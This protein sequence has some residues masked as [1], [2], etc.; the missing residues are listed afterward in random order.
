MFEKIGWQKDGPNKM[1]L[2]D[3]GP[4][5]FVVDIERATELNE[6]FR[7]T[8][9]TGKHLQLTLMNIEPGEE[10][11]LEIHPFT[12]QFLRIEEGKG[13]VRM[14]QTK[15]NL[16]FERKVEDGYAIIIPAG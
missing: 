4:E 15:E 13:L 14:G 8:L 7:T 6:A 16:N 11:G 12:D 1:L 10:I 9:W 2:R 5:P 3:F